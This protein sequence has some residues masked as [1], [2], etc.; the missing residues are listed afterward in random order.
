LYLN[1]TGVVNFVGK[2]FQEVVCWR[3]DVDAEGHGIFHHRLEH[4]A[5]QAGAL[6]RQVLQLVLRVKNN[7]KKNINN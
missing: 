2:D 6:V 5:L 4:K 3:G 7:N 1:A